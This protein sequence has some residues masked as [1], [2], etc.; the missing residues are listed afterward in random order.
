[1]RSITKGAKG[2]MDQERGQVNSRRRVAAVEEQH[3]LM[4]EDPSP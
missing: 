1:L 2:E 4:T 3:L